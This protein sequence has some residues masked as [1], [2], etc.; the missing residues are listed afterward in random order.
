MKRG[1]L[2]EYITFYESPSFSVVLWKDNKAVKLVSTYCDETSK[3]KIML[4]NWSK[5]TKIE[6]DYRLNVTECNKYMKSRFS[7]QSY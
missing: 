3:T 4:L 1:V 5:T 6:I 7:G 2:I